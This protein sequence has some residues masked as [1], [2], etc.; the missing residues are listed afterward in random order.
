MKGMEHK[1][2][3]LALDHS[4][5][6]RFKYFCHDPFWLFGVVLRRKFSKHISDDRRYLKWEYFLGMKKKLN[7]D[8][9]RTYNEKLQWSKLY[10]RNPLYTRLVDK[11]AVKEYI[12][13]VMGNDHI[14]IPTLGVWDSFDDIDFASL[15]DKFVL[16][17]THDSGGVVICTDKSKLD[18]Q[19]ARAK[20]EKSLANNYYLEHREW[21]YKDVKPRII[22][23][24]FMVDESGTE[25]KDYKFFCFDGEPKMLF[26]ATD[27]PFD[28][29]FD[30]FDIDFNHLPFTQ[31]HPNA[32]RPIEKPENFGQM[33]EIARRL[34]KGFSQVRVDLYNV[35]GKIYFGELTFA[36]FSGNVPFKPAEWDMKIGEWW[37]LPE[38]TK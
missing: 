17:T 26:I 1:T 36:H 7:L 22:A 23:E 9:P 35:N 19:A 38:V 27:R 33:V 20:L 13:S 11:Y 8:N 6:G 15:P 31:G 2:R 4:T 3:Q 18:M 16:K 37:T 12:A 21:P 29:R 25:L 5:W 14:I 34:S 10:D 30:F 32:E 24:K 28:T